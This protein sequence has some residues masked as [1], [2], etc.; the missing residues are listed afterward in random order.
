MRPIPRAIL[1][2]SISHAARVSVDQYNKPTYATPATVVNY[3]RCEPVK[4]SALKA[5]GD[6]KDDKLTVYYDCA[7]SS[8]AGIVFKELDRII[9]G[10]VYYTIRTIVD[11]SPHHVEIMLK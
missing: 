10:G 4:A 2:H 7:N 6:M 3:V 1:T 8:P 11:F 5:L 9:F